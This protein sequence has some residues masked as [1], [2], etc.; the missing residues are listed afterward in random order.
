[1]YIRSI[2]VVSPMDYGSVDVILMF[3]ECQ[4]RSCVNVT[5]EDDEVLETTEFFSITLERTPAWT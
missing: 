5:I 1:M 2:V 3:A 4:R